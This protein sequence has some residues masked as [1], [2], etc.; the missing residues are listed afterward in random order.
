[1]SAAL[2]LIEPGRGDYLLESVEGGRTRGRHSMIGLAP[3]LV[4]RAHGREAAINADWLADRDAFAACEQDSLAALADAG[5]AL[6]D[7]RARGPAQGAGLPGRLF[8]L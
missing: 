1:M 5:R 8:R 6:P 4:F 3:D 2:K 7:G